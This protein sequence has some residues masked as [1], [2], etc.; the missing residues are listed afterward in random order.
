M[1]EI[2]IRQAEAGD[3]PALRR[4]AVEALD[5]ELVAIGGHLEARRTESALGS[6]VV[7]VAECDGHRAGYIAL[8]ESGDDLVVDQLVIA[9]TERGRHVGHRLLDWAEGYGVSR[10]LTR[11]RIDVEPDNRRALEFYARRGYTAGAD[12]PV[13]ELVHI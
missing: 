8:S 5:P 3:E 9:S 10:R 1:N 13:R 12:G 11:V 4:L 7:F 2:V 6:D